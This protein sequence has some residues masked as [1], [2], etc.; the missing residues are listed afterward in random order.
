MT[1]IEKMKQWLGALEVV[2]SCIDDYYLPKEKAWL[3]EIE[4]AI[5]SLRQA[6][7][8]AER[9]DQ[10]IDQLISERDHA[11]EIIDKLCDAVLGADRHEWSSMYFFEDAVRDVEERMAEAEGQEKAL[12]SL[13]NENER[14]GLYKDAYAEQEPVAR[15]W[16]EGYRFGVNDER[17][18]EANIGIAGMGMKVEPA[19][20]NPYRTT[21]PQRTKVVFPTMLRKMWSGGE[22]QAWLDENVNKENT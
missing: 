10:Q 14:L 19:R 3:P 8:E 18:S 21:P 1:H 2:N 22:V 16:D 5:T 9:Q 20:N 13:H 7:A 17:M 12:Q 15:A 6:I 4:Q 11:H